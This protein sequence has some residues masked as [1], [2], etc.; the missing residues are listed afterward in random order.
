MKK[1]LYIMIAAVLVFVYAAFSVYANTPYPR[2]TDEADLLTDTEEAEILEKLDEISSDKQVDIVICTVSSIGEYSAMEYADNLFE[3][4]FYGMG[5]DRSCILLMISM[6]YSDWHIT[7]AGYGITALSDVGID[8]IGEQIVPMMADGNFADAFLAYASLCDRFIDMARSGDPFDADDL[9]KEPFPAFHNLIICLLIG[10]VAAWIM[11][12]KKKAQ[13][14]SVRRQSAAKN[15]TK[16]G[17]LKIHESK[18]LFLY[19]TVTKSE[20]PKNSG[21]SS[22]HTT[23]SGTTVGGGGGKF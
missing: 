20:K 21:S 3:D 23:K 7:T 10:I 16:D 11:T 14:I 6:E 18:D 2:L 8:Y 1:H 4:R 19:K 17:S 22:T 9:P 12:G 15:Y 5:N 13:L